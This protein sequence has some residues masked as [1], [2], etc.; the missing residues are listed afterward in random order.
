MHG[1]PGQRVRLVHR[2]PGPPVQREGAGEALLHPGPPEQ[3]V[4]GRQV[5]VRAAEQGHELA[6]DEVVAGVRLELGAQ[7]LG[8]L[9]VLQVQGR[10]DQERQD[11]RPQG[12]L[13]VDGQALVEQPAQQ[14][15]GRLVQLQLG[16]ERQQPRGPV[17][18]RLLPTGDQRADLLDRAGLAAHH[19]DLHRRRALGA[20]GAEV[21]AELQQG[22]AGAPG[23]RE[24]PGHE[25]PAVLQAAGHVLEEPLSGGLRH[26]HQVRVRLRP[27]T[28]AAQQVGDRAAVVGRRAEVTQVSGPVRDRRQLGGAR[29]LVGGVGRPQSVPQAGLQGVRQQPLVAGLPGAAYREDAGGPGRLGVAGERQRATQA[30]QRPDPQR[31]VLAPTGVQC[32]GQQ[33]HARVPRQ[34]RPPGRRLEE[35][36]RLEP[37]GRGGS[38]RRDLLR[39]APRAG[40]VSSQ[41]V[42]AGRGQVQ[43]VALDR[44]LAERGRLL[45][46]AGGVL[47]G[48]G[49]PGG[50]RRLDQVAHGLVGVPERPRLPVVVRQRLHPP[51]R[52]GG[53]RLQDRGD[54]GV[55]V[56]PPRGRQQLHDRLA[57]QRMR[58]A[59]AT[60]GHA[61]EE[62]VG[63]AVVQG[64][65]RGV[66]AP[67][68]G[69]HEGEDVD[70]LPHHRGQLQRLPLRLGQARQPALERVEDRDR[71]PQVVPATQRAQAAPRRQVPPELAQEERVAAGLVPQQRGRGLGAV[72]RHTCLAGE[73]V[74]DVLLGE[75]VEVQAPD[76][77]EPVQA[78]QRGDQCCGPVRSGGAVADQH[79]QGCLSR[80][81]DEVDEQVERRRAGPVQVLQHEHQRLLAAQLGEAVHD[82]VVELSTVLGLIRRPRPGSPP[83]HHV[84]QLP[85]GLV[86]ARMGEQELDRL[87][88]GLV[89]QAEVGHAGP[90]Q[91]G[92]LLGVRQGGD[93][94]EQP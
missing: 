83:G 1:Q 60:G 28:G 8:G 54:P 29:Q 80:P 24:V 38:R 57:D 82:A 61:L 22:A 19:E 77:V 63:D 9:G 23:R 34:A 55:L 89:G 87:D 27:V 13:A 3:R 40:E 53:P 59:V 90:D 56:R 36:G 51:G 52:A 18:G 15:G 30:R 17:P 42:A 93:L 12:R 85:G 14:P 50:A 88:E 4:D 76:A 41:Q 68:G 11:R 73:E 69:R 20:V 2:S 35:H 58:E 72:G 21:L 79:Q 31:V 64:R 86:V 7:T 78:R 5:A 71:R 70:L 6:R 45:V 48:Q 62:P 25:L 66:A 47:V 65:H 16:V 46:P 75:A 26:P 67:V 44:V 94:G 32:G 39:Q 43:L 49:P 37:L 74:R 33:R 84:E 10:F 92:G 91:D 81:R